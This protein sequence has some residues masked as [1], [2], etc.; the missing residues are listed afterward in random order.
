MK[1]IHIRAVQRLAQEIAEACKESDDLEIII[2]NGA[3]PFGHT[4]V[5]RKETAHNIHRAVKCLNKVL[6]DEFKAYGLNVTAIH[7]YTF[8][9]EHVKSLPEETIPSFYES[10]FLWAEIVDVAKNNQID[11]SYGDVQPLKHDADKGRIKDEDYY[12]VS[13][14]KLIVETGRYWRA[15]KVIAVW[16]EEEKIRDFIK[17]FNVNYPN[18]IDDY[19]R[20]AIDYGVRGVPEKY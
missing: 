14:D 18:L 7:P 13:A 2:N 15:D 8:S 9:V 17:E 5:K 16:D 11:S 6:I 20:V 19:G 1:Y 10:Q 3:G 4:L 12:I